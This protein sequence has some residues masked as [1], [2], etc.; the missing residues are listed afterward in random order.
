MF[1]F[2]FAAGAF[3]GL[4]ALEDEAGAQIFGADVFVG[5]QFLGRTGQKTREPP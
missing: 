3:H 4:G 2:H 5:R 1:R